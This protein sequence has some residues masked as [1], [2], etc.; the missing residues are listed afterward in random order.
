MTTHPL[1]SRHFTFLAYPSLQGLEFSFQLQTILTQSLL[2]RL[3]RL[4]GGREFL[5]PG[6]LQPIYR[7]SCSYEHKFQNY[8]VCVSELGLP[9]T[10]R[11][12]SN[13]YISLSLF[14][15]IG[16]I[17]YE[18]SVSTVE[19]YLNPAEY[20]EPAL[21][22]HQSELQEDLPPA[23]SAQLQHCAH[24]QQGGDC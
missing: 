10:K 24:W 12:L 3:A 6:F 13:F 22:T 7:R 18:Y 15:Q 23:L 17:T 5:Q 1:P 4:R 9:L 14:T 16:L 19:L 21:I 20:T 11:V 2:W 8:K